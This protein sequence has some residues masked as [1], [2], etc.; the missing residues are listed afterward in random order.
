MRLTWFSRMWEVS[1]VNLNY[2]MISQSS[3]S[4]TF[5]SVILGI[6]FCRWMCSVWTV[7]TERLTAQLR[8]IVVFLHA[9]KEHFN[10]I[11]S[12]TRVHLFGNVSKMLI[13][14]CNIQY[15]VASLV[16][17]T[18]ASTTN[19]TNFISSWRHRFYLLGRDCSM[20]RIKVT[21]LKRE[22]IVFPLRRIWFSSEN[23]NR[24]L[25]CLSFVLIGFGKH[26]YLLYMLW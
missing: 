7:N 6:V 19:S 12:V 26:K 18:Y 3:L 8:K 25:K 5:C 22:K 15:C 21:T 23:K 11:S 14:N 17:V 10:F 2:K 20:S 13:E 1:I 9:E 4:K 16:Y 24:S